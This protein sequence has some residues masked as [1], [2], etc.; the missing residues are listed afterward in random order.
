MLLIGNEVAICLH[1]QLVLAIG[2][3]KEARGVQLATLARMHSS[4]NLECPHPNTS[5]QHKKPLCEILFGAL[6]GVSDLDMSGN[7]GSCVELH[8]TSAI[9]R[10]K[11]FQIWGKGAKPLTSVTPENTPQG[12]EQNLF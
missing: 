1:G 7:K 4:H 10:H 8:V 5:S 6:C 2:R 9:L 11:V 12:V 3:L